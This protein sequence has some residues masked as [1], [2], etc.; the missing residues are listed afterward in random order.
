MNVP[1]IPV[2][3]EPIFKPKPWGGRTLARLFDKPLPPDQPIGESWEVVSLP[4]NESR[5]RGGP[6]AGRTVSEL[7][8]MWGRDLYGGAELV[9]GRFPLLIKFLDACEHLS[10]QVHPKPSAENQDDWQPG[11]KPEAWYVLHAESGAEMFVGFKPDVT[12]ADAAR[13][14][15]TPEMAKLLRPWPV[16]P[17]QCYYLPSGTPHALGAGIVVAEV[18]TP[19]DITYRLYDWNRVGFDGKPRELHIEQG[20]ANVRY[21]VRDEMILQP[22]SHVAGPFA[23]V[24]R[25]AACERFLID[26]VRLSEGVEQPVPHVEM[27]IWIV[28]AG[29]GVFVRERFECPYGPGDV[30]VIPADSTET[31]MVTRADCDLLE[32]KIPIKSA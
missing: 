30:V 18:Q 16:K 32:V 8:D 14:A 28:L 22:R 5:V 25:M 11:I 21:D 15:N 23:T 12:P 27:V 6:L 1:P 17:G 19:S 29:Q 9:E 10:V 31:R 2:V 13:A 20:L 26:K 24:T 4:G 7:I 3:F